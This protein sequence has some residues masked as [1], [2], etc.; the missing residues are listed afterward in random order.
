M[1]THRF[2]VS[3]PTEHLVP[4]FCFYH[5]PWLPSVL[6]KILLSLC[7]RAPA[8]RVTPPPYH[9]HHRLW[10]FRDDGNPR[11]LVSDNS[12]PRLHRLAVPFVKSACDHHLKG[13]PL[14]RDALKSTR[15]D[16]FTWRPIT[17]HLR[18]AYFIMDC[19][20]P[21]ISVQ[22]FTDPTPKSVHIA[23]LL[24]AAQSQLC[25]AALNGSQTSPC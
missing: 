13:H 3:C 6:S 16:Y 24:D 20:V 5:T 15:P 11:P 14:Q 1:T 8:Y 9:L 17:I 19:Y 4:L 10:S 22:R 25:A 21:C 7:A 2:K 12:V 23:Y 18:S